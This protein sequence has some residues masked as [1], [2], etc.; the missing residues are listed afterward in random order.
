MVRSSE[1]AGEDASEAG[2]ELWRGILVFKIDL[3]S[4]T[5]DASAVF[6]L[7]YNFLKLLFDFGPG[8]LGDIRLGLLG[9]GHPF[10]GFC[11]ICTSVIAA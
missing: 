11:E 8:S 4:R 10:P 6:L 1:E 9:T 7:L 3:V 5:H 2:I